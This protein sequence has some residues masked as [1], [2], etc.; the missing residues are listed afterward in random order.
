MHIIIGGAYSGKR[1][2]VREKYGSFQLISAYE[3]QS[4]KEEK[5]S[6]TVVYEG[7]EI[8]ISEL[9]KAGQSNQEIVE[10]FREWVCS[11]QEAVLIML[12]IGRGIVPIEEHDRRLRDVV[13]WVQQ[14]AVKKAD[15]VT[16]IWHGLAKRLK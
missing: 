3:G 7:F 15:E 14:E 8:W 12:E 16:S 2:F 4:M 6:D 9:I 1:Q 10:I 13:G 11:Q 5:Q